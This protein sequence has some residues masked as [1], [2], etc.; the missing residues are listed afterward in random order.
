MAA[1][2]VLRPQ[3]EQFLQLLRDHRSMT[4]QEIW[5]ALSD[6]TRSDWQNAAVCTEK[7]AIHFFYFF[8]SGVDIRRRVVED[9][10]VGRGGRPEKIGPEQQRKTDELR[11]AMS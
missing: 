5:D 2:L 11:F 7:P 1:E 3:Q 10:G 9:L 4:P 6:A 8:R